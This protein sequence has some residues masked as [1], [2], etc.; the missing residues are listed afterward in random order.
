MGST[1]A[2]N[3]PAVLDGDCLDDVCDGDTE[4][5]TVLLETFYED[6]C[7]RLAAFRSVAMELRLEEIQRAC[8]T[9]RGASLGV[10]AYQLVEAT[11]HLAELCTSGDCPLDGA[12][13]AVVTAAEATATAVQA[14]L[15]A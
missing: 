8:H 7:E 13:E 4:L 2:T 1:E 12:I 14:R 5:E 6:L 15:A 3:T 9:I 11:A 10:G